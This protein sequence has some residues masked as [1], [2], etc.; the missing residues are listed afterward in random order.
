MIKRILALLVTFVAEI[1]TI[2]AVEKI[3]IGKQPT[4]SILSNVGWWSFYDALAYAEWFLLKVVLPLVIIGSSL[5]VAY[6]L[7]LAEGNEEE[8]KKA[9]KAVSYA[10]V[11][12][13]S[14]MLAYAIIAIVQRL[15]I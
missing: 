3:S 12:V 13:I 8:N 2:F 6:K 4:N 5:Y 1:H 11:W 10:A 14:I 7:F 9:W 15:N